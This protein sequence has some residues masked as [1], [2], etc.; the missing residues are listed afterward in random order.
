MRPNVTNVVIIEPVEPDA[1]PELS[2]VAKALSNDSMVESSLL[3]R[4]R[5]PERDGIRLSH[6]IFQVPIKIARSSYGSQVLPYAQMK[7]KKI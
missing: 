7:V 2:G 1:P 6:P 4:N 3:D 5:M